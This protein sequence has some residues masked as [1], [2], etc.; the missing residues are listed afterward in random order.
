MHN[1]PRNPPRIL[2]S[3]YAQQRK[4]QH[5]HSKRHAASAVSKVRQGNQASELSRVMFG[6]A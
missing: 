4:A 2:F 5:I 1:A 3:V 6:E